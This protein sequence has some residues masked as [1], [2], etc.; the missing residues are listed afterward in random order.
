MDFNNMSDSEILQ[1]IAKNIDKKRISIEKTSQQLAD[2]GGHNMQTY[3]N[4][5]N[6]NTDI[7]LSTVIQIFR[8]LD[9][10][11][12]LQKVFEHKEE[13]SPIKMSLKKTNDKKRVSKSKVV[14]TNTIEWEK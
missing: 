11:N 2:D 5:L 14:K 7:R 4:F 12:Q 6:K 8:G 13:F 9:E 10:L 3:S 1:E